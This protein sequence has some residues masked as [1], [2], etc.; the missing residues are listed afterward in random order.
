MEKKLKHLEF[1][2]VIV[3]RMS[4]NLFYL[5]GWTVTLIV[6]LLAFLPGQFENAHI[7][8]V[9]SPIL[10]FW[11]LDSYFLSRER[12]FRA[13]YDHVRLL[14]EEDIDFSMDV[15]PFKNDKRNSWYRSMFSTTLVVFYVVLPAIV[16]IIRSII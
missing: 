15:K 5:K 8:I 1:I 3:G 2:Q 16:L 11:I 4:N 6:A 14:K 7:L 10:I 12:L 13:L 9:Y